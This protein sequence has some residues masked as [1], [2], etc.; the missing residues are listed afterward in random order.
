MTHVLMQLSSGQGPAECEH[1]VK[2]TFQEMCCD[3]STHGVSLLVVEEH[4]S[5]YGWKSLVLKA[6]GD[7]VHAWSATWNGSVQCVFI[8]PFRP[9]HRRKNWFVGVQTYSGADIEPSAAT[10]EEKDVSFQA[11]RASGAGGQHVNT[12]DSAVH[13]IHRPSGL[14]VKVM[15][16]RSQYANKKLALTLLALKLG[17]MQ[18]EQAKKDKQMRHQQHWGLERGNPI[19]TLRTT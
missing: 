15:A 11:C 10:V 8:S 12:T 1:A 16:E 18:Q 5:I 6:S 19:K 3:A 17:S 2:R 13:A 9:G 4:A 7:N 14:S